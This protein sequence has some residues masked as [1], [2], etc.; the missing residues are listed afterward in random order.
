MAQK[1]AFIAA[2]G[3]ADEF[4][5]QLGDKIRQKA[6][7]TATELEALKTETQNLRA[8]HGQPFDSETL[9]TFAAISGRSVDDFKKDWQTDA[10]GVFQDFVT[11]LGAEGD[12]AAL[13]LESLGLGGERVKTSFL[14]LS[15]AGD[16]LSETMA[17]A[18]EQF[19][20]GSA[21]QDEAANRFATT[22]SQITLLK[23]SFRAMGD[24][25]GTALLPF[26]NELLGWA[27][28]FLNQWAGPM[29]EALN[30]Q[31]VPALEQVSTFITGVL[32]PALGLF[33]TEGGA[34]I[35]GFVAAFQESGI[36][37]VIESFKTTIIEGFA[38][39]PE[40]LS[41]I[42][43]SM[44]TFL[45]EQGPNIAES[46]QGW[47]T[48][49][50]DWV[51]T[52]VNM[53]GQALGALIVAVAAWVTSDEGQGK[54]AE[55]GVALGEFLALGIESF[56]ENEGRIIEI[57]TKLA[58]GLAAA[59]GAITAIL[60]SVGVQITAGIF[61]GLLNSITDGGWEAAT[62][63]EMGAILSGIGSNI[64]TI[65]QHVGVSI[66]QGIIDGIAGWVEVRDALITMVSS[67]I[68]GFKSFLGISSPSTIFFGFG[69]DIIQGLLDGIN[70]L[71]SSVAGAVSSVAG[72]AVDTA[73]GL[74]GSMFGGGEE[75]GQALAVDTSGLDVDLSPF[76]AQLTNDVPA[77]FAIF[78]ETINVMS[79]LLREVFL[80]VLT[81][82]NTFLTDPFIPTLI[83]L[84]E[85]HF[86]TLNEIVTKA[87]AI[88]RDELLASMQAVY[89]FIISSL[90][91]SLMQLAN[92]FTTVLNPAIKEASEFFSTLQSAI[93]KIPS[94]IASVIM[95]IKELA[96]AFKKL[97]DAM[98]K[99]LKPGSPSPFEIS[100][101][102]IAGTLKK[103]NQLASQSPLFN[104]TAGAMASAGSIAGALG[105]VG[106]TGMTS[107]QDT[108]NNFNL[109]INSNASNENV[110]QDFNLMKAMLS[111][112]G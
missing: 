95:K 112:A 13:A 17:E 1:E 54:M 99:W 82:I 47:A 28:D 62:L 105:S 91:P 71:A 111:N 100:L 24:T 32:V 65:A 20:D 58:V 21:L 40:T 94:K 10:A 89:D 49:F 31:V 26:L 5:R 39:I 96:I 86:P 75:S 4:G 36:E 33:A 48:S 106:Q 29:E 44:T 12:N 67:A 42:M 59:A 83:T 87:G 97:G 8:E 66:L 2:G 92:T 88:L 50:F 9:A 74:F 69:T 18:N 23:N 108:I 34:A 41:L 53:A 45:S 70:S 63:N 55:F 64:A 30:N 22:E 90:I 72:A 60:L 52:A 79:T 80:L 38:A 93:Q 43:E 15:G 27:T 77:A 107:S 98:P 37:G 81:E 7:E 19:T 110:V 16:L 76:I 3:S 46:V 68:E 14:A 61:E 73:S 6:F 84:Y 51:N 25:I 102:N 103:V 85:T 56:F 57:M 109:T 101:G 78:Q 11:G 104:P 35:S